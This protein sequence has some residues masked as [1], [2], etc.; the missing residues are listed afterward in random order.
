MEIEVNDNN[1]NENVLIKSKEVPVVVDFWAQ[2][3][4]PCLILGPV[5][6]KLSKEFDG[7]FILAKANVDQTRNYAQQYQVRGIPSVKMFKNGKITDEFVGVM[8]EENI[9]QWLNKNL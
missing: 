9:K 2:W 8:P 6:E 1:F 5:L 4:A 7:K 3:C